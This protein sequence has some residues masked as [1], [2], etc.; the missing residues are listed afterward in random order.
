MIVTFVTFLECNRKNQKLI[1]YPDNIPLTIHP[2]HRPSMLV[3]FLSLQIWIIHQVH[4]FNTEYKPSV[5][6]SPQPISSDELKNL[7]RDTGLSEET[8]KLLYS[9]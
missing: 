2:L 6:D 8:S 1:S 5:C 3:P 4:G 7:T 9:R